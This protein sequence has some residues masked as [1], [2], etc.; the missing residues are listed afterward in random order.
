LAKIKGFAPN[1]CKFSDQLKPEQGNTYSL[2]YRD[3]ET[4]EITLV[5]TQTT[6]YH[7]AKK[8]AKDIK[9]KSTGEIWQVD[10]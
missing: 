10:P 7:V 2:L 5:D 4:N 3:T 8:Q 6:N 1:N 9:P